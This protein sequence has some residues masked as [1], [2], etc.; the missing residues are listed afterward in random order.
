MGLKN[1]VH[2]HPNVSC[3]LLTNVGKSCLFG[4]WN[5]F[6]Y[7]SIDVTIVGGTNTVDEGSE[8]EFINDLEFVWNEL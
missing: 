8:N 6:T 4:S 7:V 1:P 5:A 2:S 3:C